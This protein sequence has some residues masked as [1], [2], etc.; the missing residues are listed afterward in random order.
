MADSRLDFLCPGNR[1]GKN[2]EDLNVRLLPAHPDHPEGDGTGSDKEKGDGD[3]D[4]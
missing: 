1:P 3:E 4:G 2:R